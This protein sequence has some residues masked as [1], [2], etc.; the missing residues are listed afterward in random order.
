MLVVMVEGGVA[1]LRIL[2]RDLRGSMWRWRKL[3]LCRYTAFCSRFCVSLS[4]GRSRKRLA[5]MS[6]F[7]NESISRFRTFD[8]SVSCCCEGGTSGSWSAVRR[9]WKVGR[10]SRIPFSN[11]RR[12]R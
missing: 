6:Y 2:G 8:A 9:R 10:R 12:V 4:V 7:P 1:C 11:W 3:L 5:A